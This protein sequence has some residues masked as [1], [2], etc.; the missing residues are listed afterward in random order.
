MLCVVDTANNTFEANQIAIH[1]IGGD[2]RVI[3]DLHRPDQLGLDNG[4]FLYRANN[5]TVI[6]LDSLIRLTNAKEPELKH[7]GSGVV[8]SEV[9]GRLDY[10]VDS[11]GNYAVKPIG[12][13][14]ELKELVR[15]GLIGRV[16]SMQEYIN[17]TRDGGNGPTR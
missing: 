16:R 15:S 17:T 10:T 12:V 14:L 6:S 5:A 8:E 9:L 13:T 1:P 4:R 3:K 2:F 11:D 7:V